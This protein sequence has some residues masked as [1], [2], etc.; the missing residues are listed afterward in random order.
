MMKTDG[1]KKSRSVIR[2]YEK[3]P[4]VDY[5]ESLSPLATNTTIKVTIALTMEQ[6]ALHEDWVIEMVDDE[7][8]FLNGPVDTDIYIELPEGLRECHLR[9]Y[10]EVDRFDLREDM[11]IRLKRAQYGLVQSPQLWMSIFAKIL[12]KLGLVQCKTDP[13]LFTLH[14]EDGNLLAIVEVYC[15]NSIITGFREAFDRLKRGI[16]S[17]VTISDLGKLVRHHGVDYEFGRDDYGA[18]MKSSMTEYKDKRD[19]EKDLATTLKDYRT[20]GAAVTPPL[21]STSGD[22][23]VRQE[24]FRSYVGRVMFACMKT[25][26]TISNACQELTC[27]LNAPNE[28]HWTGLK[29]LI[30]YLKNEGFQGLKMRAPNDRRVVAFVDSNYASDRGDRKS[31][32]GYLVTIGSCLVPW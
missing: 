5:V 29:Y 7:A 26:P 4:G 23:I 18:Y 3:N 6:M 30:G 13:C 1:S 15:N 17:A 10:Q 12:A 31:I 25:E 22:E 14:D 27:H 9:K 21:H 24:L 11:I 2:G 28:T 19:F 32:S 8:A 20:P 16:S